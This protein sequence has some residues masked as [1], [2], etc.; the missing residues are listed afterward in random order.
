MLA[1]TQ[2]RRGSKLHDL[3]TYK[4]KVQVVVTLAK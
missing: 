4:S 1:G 3:I 2:I